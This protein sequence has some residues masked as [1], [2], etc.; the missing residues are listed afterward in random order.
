MS[1]DVTMDIRPYDGE[2]MT[3]ID[4]TATCTNLIV[5][6]LLPEYK[7]LQDGHL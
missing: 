5:Q 1:T 3:E 4:V 7:Q 2:L 6:S